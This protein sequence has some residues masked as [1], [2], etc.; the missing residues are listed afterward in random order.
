MKVHEY[1]IDKPSKCGWIVMELCD[2]NISKIFRKLSNESK[3][4]M[5]HEIIKALKSLHKQ[6]ICHR[7]IK[8]ENI[9]IK[10]DPKSQKVQIKLTDFGLSKQIITQ[11]D[12]NS[13]VGTIHYMANEMVTGKPYHEKVDSWAM[14][15]VFM[16]LWT[17]SRASS[18]AN[19][20]VPSMVPNFPRE[21]QLEAITDLK[22]REITRKV[23][24]K[25]AENRLSILDISTKK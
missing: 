4:E 14:G 24:V 25:D 6:K 19:G 3:V 10:T 7:D 21:E 2:G 23:L 15:I 5:C 9:L 8:L 17:N 16:E 22:L 18:F 1:F 13:M 20:G 12:M 11:Q